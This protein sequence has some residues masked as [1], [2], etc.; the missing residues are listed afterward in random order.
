MPPSMY[1]II[2]LICVLLISTIYLLYRTCVRTHTPHTP[3]IQRD[4]EYYKNANKMYWYLKDDFTTRHTEYTSTEPLEYPG[5]TKVP[6]APRRKIFIPRNTVLPCIFIEQDPE[7]SH[8]KKILQ[9]D[10]FQ[11]TTEGGDLSISND[12]YKYT[13]WR[14]I[15]GKTYGIQV[16]VLLIIEDTLYDLDGYEVPFTTLERSSITVDKKFL[17]IFT[18]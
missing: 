4:F 5:H 9:L 17:C 2:I 16:D 12:N 13:M 11:R 14:R 7:V 10:R 6:F 1:D 3:H 18:D 8:K 15:V